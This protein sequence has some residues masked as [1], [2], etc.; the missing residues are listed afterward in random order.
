[1]RGGE[2]A[3]GERAEGKEVKHFQTF[4]DCG[5]EGE[6]RGGGGGRDGVRMVAVENVRSG[7]E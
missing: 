4:L 6:R 3:G 1:M 2:E 5:V 7:D